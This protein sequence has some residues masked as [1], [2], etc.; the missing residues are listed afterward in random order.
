MHQHNAADKVIQTWKNHLIA[1]TP[2][3]F[4]VIAKFCCL[5]KQCMYTLNMLCPNQ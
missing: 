2:S 1:G 5:T 3:H 4:P